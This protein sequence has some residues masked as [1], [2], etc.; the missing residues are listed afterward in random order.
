V[1]VWQF[2]DHHFVAII[3]VV[4]LAVFHRHTRRLF[5][6]VIDRVKLA[7]KLTFPGGSIEVPASLPEL[8][9]A[10]TGPTGPRG[11]RGPTGPAGETGPYET[12]EPLRRS[13][14]PRNSIWSSPGDDEDRR[15]EV[16]RLI[17]EAFRWGF[18][19]AGSWPGRDTPEV[20]VRWQDP[21]PPRIYLTGAQH[22]SVVGVSWPPAG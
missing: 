3:V 21:Q 5:D 12:Q 20:N 2:I 1:N 11:P 14:G 10:A 13:T 6:A 22:R 19:A 18:D 9:Q 17:Q 15:R 16:E 8:A 4:F 7:S